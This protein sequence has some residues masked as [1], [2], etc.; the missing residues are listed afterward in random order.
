MT[1]LADQLQLPQL[2]EAA[3]KHMMQS[4]HNLEEGECWDHLT[5]EL[6]ER[7]GA[8]QS[9]IKSSIH[10]QRS[11]LYFGS[12]QEYLAIFAE[13]V[14][15]YKERLAEAMEQQAEKEQSPSWY[16]TQQKI[17]R[18]RTRLHTLQVAFK[19]QKKLF[20]RNLS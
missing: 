18:Q 4:V 11:A 7:I 14:H 20:G 16:D 3:L 13:R 1:Q 12:L 2:F 10:D 17:E 8:I 15:Y 9:A 5:P 6:R 19:E